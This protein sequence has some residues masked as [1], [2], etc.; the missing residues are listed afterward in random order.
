MNFLAGNYL[1]PSS[2]AQKILGYFSKSVD[3][4]D[5]NKSYNVDVQLLVSGKQIRSTNCI[6]PPNLTNAML[7]ANIAKL[8]IASS[9][10]VDHFGF[11]NIS[12]SLGPCLLGWN[13]SSFV[14]IGTKHRSQVLCVN[15]KYPN[16][17]SSNVMK[18]SVLNQL[19]AKIA[20][21]IVKWNSMVHYGL[22]NDMI[23]KSNCS[24]GQ[25]FALT[26]LKLIDPA[27]ITF[28][29][30]VGMYLGVFSPI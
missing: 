10:G 13:S 18:G 7:P 3:G 21:E 12:L 5:D 28:S 29:P 22:L 1:N 17:T 20:D 6:A 26:I 2:I 23:S 19:V 30:H 25:V 8:A 14:A 27:P 4:V 24:N 15:T 11:G 9:L 16:Q